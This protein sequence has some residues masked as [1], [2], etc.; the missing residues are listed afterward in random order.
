MSTHTQGE[1]G[2]RNKLKDASED[3]TLVLRF[4][5]GMTV[6]PSFIYLEIYAD[7]FYYRSRKSNMDSIIGS[8]ASGLGVK[9]L[10][11]YVCM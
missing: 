4:K 6:T 5:M 10:S 7:R 8:D 11:S 2:W 3:G 9:T 1:G